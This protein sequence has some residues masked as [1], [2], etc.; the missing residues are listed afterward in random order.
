MAQV[1]TRTGQDQKEHFHSHIL[2]TVMV[3]SRSHVSP[4]GGA[5]LLATEPPVSLMDDSCAANAVRA[6]HGLGGCEL[7][8][9][10]IQ[11]PL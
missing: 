1:C 9:R 11:A 2:D 7:R 4:D 5:W 6:G 8:D 3:R 10:P